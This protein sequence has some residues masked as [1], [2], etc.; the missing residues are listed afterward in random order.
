MSTICIVGVQWGD[1]GKGKIVDILSRNID[2][3][4]RFNGGANAGHTVFANGKKFIFHQIPCGILHKGV[5]SVI[6]N[7]VVVDPLQLLTEIKN[8]RNQGITVNKKLFISDRAHLVMPYHKL[9]DSLSESKGKF[10]IGTTQRGIGPCYADKSARKGLRI[11]D[12]YNKKVFKEKL[13]SLVAEKNKI[14]TC[15]FSHKPLNAK[16]IFEEYIRYAKVLKPFV[17]DTIELVNNAIDSGKNV[18]FEGAQGS[19]L[20]LD[21]GTYPYVTSSNS[22]AACSVSS[23]SGVPPHKIGTILGVAKAYSTRVGEG[24][25]PTEL[26][27][28]EGNILRKKGN[29][30]GSTTGRPRRCGWFDGVASKYAVAINGITEL[31]ITKL[32]VLSGLD[33]IKICIGYKCNGNIISKVPA[34]IVKLSK[35]KPIYKTF[36][37]WDDNLLSIKRFSDLP[38]NTKK[39]L[40]FIEDFIGAKIKIISMGIEREQTIIK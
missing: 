1:E 39:Y 28:E 36:Q 32:D 19:M 13:G 3:A 24:P 25:F 14:L 31:A 11:I 2:Y 30:F 6:A 21:F 22:A 35:C 8:L 37:G 17:R 15:L 38:H 5:V 33:E 10:K 9:L 29:E 4:V 34:D 27:G 20:D 18:L 26:L 7:G 23:G 12:L 40:K 16:H